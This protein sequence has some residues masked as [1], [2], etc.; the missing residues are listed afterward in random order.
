MDQPLLH[1]EVHGAGGPYLLL[2]HG[3]LSSRAQWLANIPALSSFCRPLVV[4]LFG[5]GR[6]PSPE[7]PAPYSPPGYVEE[8]ER[9]RQALGVDRWLLC[10]QSLGAALTLRY[11]LDHPERVIG[12]VFTNSM[13][14]MASPG[15]SDYVRPLM[16]AQAERLERD[17]RRAIENHPLNPSRG[18]RLPAVV[19]DAL[20]EDC[21]LHDLRGVAFTGLYTVPDS[22]VRDRIASNSVPSLLIVGERE[23]R[24]WEYRLFAEEHMPH[25]TVAGFDA[26][27]SV[28]AEVADGFDRAVED[29]LRPFVDS[30]PTIRAATGRRDG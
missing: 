5:H 21:R 15:W 19:R 13:S 11:T 6:S 22:S 30:T 14:A 10:G 18:S 12:Q 17:G 3:M 7:D 16:Q 29:F 26:G 25:L 2:V 8:F 27:H 20:V 4:E 23:E 1:Y 28:N 24:F 9:L